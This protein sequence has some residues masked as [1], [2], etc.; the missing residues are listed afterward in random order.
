[1]FDGIF[2][3]SV[4]L[5]GGYKALETRISGILTPLPLNNHKYSTKLV[6]CFRNTLPQMDWEPK[7]VRWDLPTLG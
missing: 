2:Q 3:L 1:M 7:H 5:K 4:S 6:I